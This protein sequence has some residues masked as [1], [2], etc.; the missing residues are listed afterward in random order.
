MQPFSFFR[1]TWTRERV[2]E[3]NKVIGVERGRNSYGGRDERKSFSCCVAGT[4]AAKSSFLPKFPGTVKAVYCLNGGAE[5]VRDE[6]RKNTQPN[7]W[8]YVCM[9]VCRS[10]RRLR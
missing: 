7:Y 4:A 9:C 6:L 2:K 1:G 5:Q 8:R 3:R 10:E